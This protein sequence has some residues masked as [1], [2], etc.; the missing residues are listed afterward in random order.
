VRKATLAAVAVAILAAAATPAHA[1]R[2][3]PS[4]CR[5]DVS[6]SGHSEPQPINRGGISELKVTPKNDG[7]DGA[8]AIDLQ[9]A[10]APGLQVIGV[11][12]YGGNA[13]WRLSPRYIK[14]AMGDF[15]REQ[16][17]VVRVKVRGLTL[18]THISHAKVFAYDVMEPNGGNN[19][20]SMT[21]G[22]RDPVTG[23]Q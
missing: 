13:C 22:V 23:R 3:Y 1:G 7:P 19:Q 6:V 17:G 9:I 11:T 16:E 15:R 20:V 8:L 5:A 10:V 21:T 4:A 18:G 2:C 14:C 12:W